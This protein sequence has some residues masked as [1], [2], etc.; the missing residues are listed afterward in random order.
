MKNKLRYYRFLSDEMTQQNLA[1]KVRVARQ[2]II[3]IEK[4]TF[5]PSV[6]LALKLSQVLG[7]KIE[8]MFALEDEDW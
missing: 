2:T 5:N 8:E 1:E 4:G 7:A 6:K 3:A